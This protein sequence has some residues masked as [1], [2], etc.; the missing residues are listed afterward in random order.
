MLTPLVVVDVVVH[1][2]G[3]LL[4][5][6]ALAATSVLPLES[7]SKLLQEESV[8]LDLGLELMELF[9]VRALRSCRGKVLVLCCR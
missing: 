4:G 7:I 6:S 3:P 9:Q 5:S 1:I 8:L 2:T